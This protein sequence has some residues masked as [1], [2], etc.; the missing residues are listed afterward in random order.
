M[1]RSKLEQMKAQVDALDANEH[2][3]LYY[4]ISQFTT[5]FTKTTNGVFVSSDKLS[6]ECLEQIET[7][8]QF[9]SDQRKRMEEDQ[10]QRKTYE[11][12]FE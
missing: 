9:C 6:L 1:N 11:R 3:Q 10:K 12:I 4:I 8:I 5:E 2:K 7:H